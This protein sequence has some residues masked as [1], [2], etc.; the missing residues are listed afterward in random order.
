MTETITLSLWV[1][2]LPGLVQLDLNVMLAGLRPHADF[3]ELALVRVRPVL[4]LLLLVLEFAV[5]HDAADWRPL[6]GGNFHEIQIGFARARVSASS[7]LMIPNNCPSAETTRT[8]EMRICSLILCCCFSIATILFVKQ[9]DNDDAIFLPHA[10]APRPN[11]L[12]GRGVVNRAA[13]APAEF[14]APGPS[15]SILDEWPR[16][17]KRLHPQF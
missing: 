10:P 15:A 17:V 9:W 14:L 8:G 4:L 5:V 16:G 3:L 11:R 1:R 6:I 2:N 12:H 7:V 13:L